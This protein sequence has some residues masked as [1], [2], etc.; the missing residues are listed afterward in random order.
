[1]SSTRVPSREFL[2]QA[3]MIVRGDARLEFFRVEGATPMASEREGYET[4][5]RIGG[6]NH[7]AL[8]V[9]DLEEAV[10]ALEAEGVEIVSPPSN[11]P[12]ASGDRFAFIHD[13]ERMLVEVFQPA[14]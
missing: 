12:N 4:N 2:A 1:M 9:D 13:N 8:A 10:A 7:L 11:V 6:V 5:F 3:T 14:A